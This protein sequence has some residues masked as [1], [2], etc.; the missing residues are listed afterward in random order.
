M[1][2][3]PFTWPVGMGKVFHG[4]M[5]LREKQMRVFKPGEDRNK[6]DDEILAGSTTRRMRSGSACSTSKPPARSSC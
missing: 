3:V 4:V 6:D 1:E 2:V 5:D